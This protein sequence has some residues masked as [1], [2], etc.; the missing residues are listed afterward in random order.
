MKKRKMRK[1]MKRV[2]TPSTSSTAPDASAGDTL[3]KLRGSGRKLWAN[4]HADEYIRRLRD[5]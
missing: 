3:L 2:S 5:D 1:R 4:E